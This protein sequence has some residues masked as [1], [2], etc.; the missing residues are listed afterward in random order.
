MVTVTHYVRSSRKPPEGVCESHKVGECAETAGTF[1]HR[2]SEVIL[3]S[4]TEDTLH[5]C[6]PCAELIEAAQYDIAERWAI[7]SVEA[8][9]A[10]G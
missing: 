2:W 10:D 1:C 5:V 4:N 6:T 8:L 9:E 7:M 3:L